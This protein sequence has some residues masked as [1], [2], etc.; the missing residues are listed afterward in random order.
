MAARNY[1]WAGAPLQRAS[2][3]AR[4]SQLSAEVEPAYKREK[5]CQRDSVAILQ[6]ACEI[7][8]SFRV[9]EHFRPFCCE[10]CRREKKNPTRVKLVHFRLKNCVKNRNTAKGN[11]SRVHC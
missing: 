6:P 9:E 2:K 10:I 8:T 1:Q 11:F 4:V 7:K 3:C 5:F